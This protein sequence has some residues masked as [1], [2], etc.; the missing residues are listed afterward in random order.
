MTDPLPYLSQEQVEHI[1]QLARLGLSQEDVD[2]FRY[3]LSRVLEHFQVLAKLDTE[4]IPPTAQ[5]IALQNVMR[6]DESMASTPWEEVMANA[7]QR[8][9]GCFKVRAVLEG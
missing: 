6:S 1:C 5:V 9:E 2:R 7:P 8:E 4:G 3:Q